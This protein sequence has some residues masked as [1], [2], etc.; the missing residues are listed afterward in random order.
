M[1]P[2]AAPRLALAAAAMVAAGAGLGVA[3]WASGSSGTPQLVITV[4]SMKSA[5]E[6]MGMPFSACA[7]AGAMVWADL[8]RVKNG[9]LKLL[10]HSGDGHV[11]SAGYLT[12]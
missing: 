6:R 4:M 2:V 9:D 1:H 10:W 12:G 5:I 7:V 3:T 11:L 8:K